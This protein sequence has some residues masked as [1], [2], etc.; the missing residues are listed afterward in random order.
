MAQFGLQIWLCDR[1]EAVVLDA[2]QWLQTV[3][4]TPMTS[5][6]VTENAEPSDNSARSNRPGSAIDLSLSEHSTATTDDSRQTSDSRGQTNSEWKA[7]IT[8]TRSLA[9]LTPAEL[10]ELRIDLVLECVPEQISLKKRVLRQI[11]ELFPSP[12]IIAS[13]SSYFVPSMTCQFVT[14][15]QRFAHLHFHVPVLRQSVCDI[16]GCAE[17]DAHV[18]ERLVA[19][20]ERIEQ[21]PIQLRHEHPGYI[22][23]WLLQSVLKGALELVAMDVVDPKQVD[24]SWKAVTG[25]PLGPFGIM[26][27]IGLDVIEQVLSNARWA[28]PSAVNDQQLLAVIQPLIKSGKL[29]VKTQGGFYDYPST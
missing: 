2:I 16:V 9:G 28:A 6:S 10:S 23:N 19:L 17:T 20:A 18:L 22:F 13:N 15:P 7:R 3:P 21:P 1:N 26:D 24:Q 11:S 14:D 8:A 5:F 27:Q 29:G 25:M 12:C 4:D